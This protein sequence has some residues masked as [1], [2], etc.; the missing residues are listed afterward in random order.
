MHAFM[1]SLMHTLCTPY[2]HR[3]R[4]PCG[5][6]GVQFAVLTS[7]MPATMMS[8]T[9]PIFRL[10]IAELVRT[11]DC[12]ARTAPVKTMAAT[13]GS[14]VHRRRPC[15]QKTL[16]HTT[17]LKQTRWPPGCR[18]VL[19]LKLLQ[20]QAG[21]V[22]QVQYIWADGTHLDPRAA[23]RGEPGHHQRRHQRCEH[24]DAT[25]LD[26]ACGGKHLWSV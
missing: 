18:S 4:A 25:V 21:G 16:P 11:D 20:R 3:S 14:H 13:D 2:A 6:S 10:V 26:M 9:I 12:G 17:P 24:A 8:S 15:S 19:R 5:A 1:H 23:E 7:G 22:R